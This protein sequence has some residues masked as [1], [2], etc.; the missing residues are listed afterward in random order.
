M[1]LPSW[2]ECLTFFM[3]WCSCRTCGT[4]LVRRTSYWL[5][6]G[7][8]SPCNI[9]PRK[10]RVSPIHR[11]EVTTWSAHMELW[12]GLDSFTT[13]C[14][15]RYLKLQSDL[16]FPSRAPC[17]ARVSAALCLDKN[18]WLGTLQNKSIL[19]VLLELKHCK[20]L[21]KRPDGPSGDFLGSS[22]H[23]GSLC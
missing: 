20:I 5:Q 1:W 17:L 15:P 6:T 3:T 18:L 2:M 21:K 22:R 10:R 9:C 8:G 19:L 14:C 23:L 16:K 11:C 13:R 7:A 4:V 12:K